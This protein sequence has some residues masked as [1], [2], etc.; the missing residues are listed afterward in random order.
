VT[1][2]TH[3]S[4]ARRGERGPGAGPAFRSPHGAARAAGPRLRVAPL[5]GEFEVET[6]VE[7]ARVEPR[8][9]RRPIAAPQQVEHVRHGDLVHVGDHRLRRRTVLSLERRAGAKRHSFHGKGRHPTPHAKRVRLR[10]RGAARGAGRGG[11]R[12]LGCAARRPRTRALRWKFSRVQASPWAGMSSTTTCTILS[13]N[14]VKRAA[15]SAKCSG[16]GTFECVRVASTTT[17]LSRRRPTTVSDG[18]FCETH[19]TT[20]PSG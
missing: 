20:I 6:E 4:P 17:N 10:R 13:A 15:F 5:P 16:L 8:R 1:H 14:G 19:A 9:R 2:P 7:E 12:S 18:P 3:T 11:T